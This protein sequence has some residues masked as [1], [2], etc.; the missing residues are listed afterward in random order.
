[1]MSCVSS[2]ASNGQFS[3]EKFKPYTVPKQPKPPA[4]DVAISAIFFDSPNNDDIN[5]KIICL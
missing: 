5:K 2:R 3:S 1:M 4:P